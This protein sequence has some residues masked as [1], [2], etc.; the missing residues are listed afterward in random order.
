MCLKRPSRFVKDAIILTISGI[1]ARVIGT[2]YNV[3]VSK[4]IG[5]E[6]LGVYQMLMSL[7]LFGTNIAVAGL[8]L[9]TIKMVSKE[10]ALNNMDRI[11]E[12]MKKVV[13]Y[14]IV[15]GTIAAFVIIKTSDYLVTRVFNNLITPKTIYV[16]AI[17]LPFLSVSYSLN[18]YFTA[19][20]KVFKSALLQIFDEIS[21]VL[22]MTYLLLKFLPGNIESACIALVLGNTICEIIYT[23]I[24][25]LLYKIEEKKELKFS[26][27]NKNTSKEIV[28]VAF[29]IAFTA[30]IRSGLNTLKQVTIPKSL[31]RSNMS[32]NKAISEYGVVNGMALPII[33][34]MSVFIQPF[35]SLLLPQFS[36]YAAKKNKEKILSTIDKVF[37]T[38]ICY[39]VC[40]MGGLWAFSEDL[41]QVI[42][43]NTEVG[44]YIKMLCPLVVFSYLDSTVDSMLRGLDKQISVMICNIVDL[45]VS[46]SFIYFV[47]PYFG[48]KGYI[49]S[50][51]LSTILNASISIAILIH[52]TKFEFK[53]VKWIILPVCVMVVSILI[54]NFC[55]M[56]EKATYITLILKIMVYATIYFILWLIYKKVVKYK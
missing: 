8:S 7:Y 9:T 52:T 1:I 17:S 11:F 46:I 44:W 28:A 20:R 23:G 13:V 47:V 48:V 5:T 6:A 21:K 40:I 36:E 16:L 31:E 15:M 25:Y 32:Y 35:S 54:T 38:S 56:V 39:A 49:M 3:Y 37:S 12:I 10:M 22:V 30:C 2:A 51:F 50:I 27:Q 4:K 19:R 55:V 45:I 42:Y 29:P 41:G 33:S 43:S 18:G 53:L 34:F 24:T 26:V 14:C